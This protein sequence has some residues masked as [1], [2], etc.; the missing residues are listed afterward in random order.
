MEKTSKVNWNKPA[1]AKVHVPIALQL[2]RIFTMPWT[3]LPPRKS[4]AH[5]KVF[6]TNPAAFRVDKVSTQ[7]IKPHITK[8]RCIKKQDPDLFL[9]HVFVS[10]EGIHGRYV[11]SFLLSLTLQLLFWAA[12]NVTKH[13][14]CLESNNGNNGF[15]RLFRV[16]CKSSVAIL[17]ALDEKRVT[18]H[19]SWV[20]CHLRPRV[21]SQSKKP[22]K[23]CCKTHH[24]R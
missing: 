2:E 4:F 8:N 11:L 9:A 23:T 19:S 13:A 12:L 5:S 7:S 18:Y 16:K 3:S 17:L 22:Q 14:K 10:W 21:R 20:L 6:C 24:W 15:T 1:A